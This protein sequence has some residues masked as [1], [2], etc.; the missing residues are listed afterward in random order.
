MAFALRDRNGHLE[1]GNFFVLALAL[2]TVGVVSWW[3]L[4]YRKGKS[5]RATANPRKLFSAI[6]RAHQLDRSQQRILLLLVQWNHLSQPAA[7]FLRPDLFDADHLG[8]KFAV[9]F[10][11][12]QKLRLQLFGTGQLPLKIAQPAQKSA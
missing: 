4:Y 9:Q 11:Q 5:T 12:I 2:V 6:C 1:T 8:T 3:A 10:A 7:V